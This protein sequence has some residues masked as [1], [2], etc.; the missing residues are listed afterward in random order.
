MKFSDKILITG[1]KG[2]VGSALADH[3]ITLGFNN[4]TVSGREDCDLL[5]SNATRKYF[6]KL[7]PDYVFHSAARVYGI[8]GNI[9]NKAL[10]FLDGKHQCR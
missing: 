6:E 1:G 8:M 4:V 10:S 2:L 3:L 7:Q 5:D 9:K